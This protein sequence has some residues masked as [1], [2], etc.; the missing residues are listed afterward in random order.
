MLMCCSQAPEWWATLRQ[1]PSGVAGTRQA[2][3]EMAAFV[4]RD[5]TDLGLR[6]FALQIVDS[7]AGHDF[8]GEM[9]RLFAYV[10]DRIT[11]RRAPVGTQ[12]VADARRTLQM[13]VGDCA[14]KSVLLA[15]LLA[16][17]GHP[18][19]FVILSFDGDDYQHVFIEAL[20]S[21]HWVAL[22]PTNEQARLGWAQ[23]AVQVDRYQIF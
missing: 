4:Q 5:S 14:M 23:S 3:A 10:R 12:L 8:Q 9:Q 7:A 21:G 18:S 22:D 15:T 1:L 13:G 2:L 16:T 17:I 20:V 19:Q 11:Y 6:N